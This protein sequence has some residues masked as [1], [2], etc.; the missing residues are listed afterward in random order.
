MA[1]ETLNPD[2]ILVGM[3]ITVWE[4]LPP[5]TDHSYVGEALTVKA[6]QLPF[7]VVRGQRGN[8]DRRPFTL[9]LRRCSVARLKDD[10]AAAL[11]SQSE[12]VEAAA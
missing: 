10:Y 2:E 11:I 12:Q 6:V 8:F 9:D 5:S 3:N 4:W 7:V 1:N